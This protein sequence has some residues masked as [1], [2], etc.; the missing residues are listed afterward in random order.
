MK[1]FQSS[2]ARFSFLDLSALSAKWYRISCNLDIVELE[3]VSEHAIFH[4]ALSNNA[5][6]W[7]IVDDDN[8]FDNKPLSTDAC[9]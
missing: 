8:L 9:P 2:T 7:Y 4:K 3:L 6:C 1:V 5:I